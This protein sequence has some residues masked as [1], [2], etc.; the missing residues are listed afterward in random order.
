MEERAEWVPDGHFNSEMVWVMWGHWG[1][2]QMRFLKET[3]MK[4]TSF[5]R[6]T[7][8]DLTESGRIRQVLG[9]GSL[10]IFMLM[11]MVSASG[12]QAQTFTVLHDFALGTGANPTNPGIIAQGRDGSL[13]STTVGGCGGFNLDGSVFRVSPAG[14]YKMV[15]CLSTDA[16]L[17]GVY[18]GVTL[19]S[20]GN[21]YGTTYG[22]DYY[23]AVFKASAA[24]KVT[25]GKVFGA[26]PNFASPFAPPVLGLDGNWYGT[27]EEGGSNGCTYG[28]GGCGGMY[29][30]ASSFKNY[31][32]LDTLQ[33]TNGANPYSPL[34]LGSDGD[35][36]GTTYQG[37]P[38]YPSGGVIFKMTPAGVHTVL[39]NLCALHN[40]C[41]DGAN[42]L[43]GLVQ[44]AD[45]EFYG[46]ASSGG[47][48][49]YAGASA[50]GLIFKVSSTGV[51]QVLYNFCSQTSCTDGNT[52]YGG[53]VLGSD[54]NFYGTTQAGGTHNYGTIFQLTPAGNLTVLYNFDSTTGSYPE[55]T[56]VQ[57]TNGILYGDTHNGGTTNYGTFF[58]L[59]LGLPPFA[60]LVTWWGKVGGTV[61]ILGQ[62][63]KHTTSVSFNGVPA[64]TFKAIGDTYISATVPTGATSGPVT[65]V[66]ATG[67][68]TSSQSFQLQ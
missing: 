14:V 39:Y 66:T 24:G 42:P 60:K 2:F 19:G 64:T 54:G 47:T 67:T 45:G 33:Q 36:Y 41:L 1:Q 21:F 28:F 6:T 32:Q 25:F 30:I 29:K 40:N 22:G 50:G 13:Y 8:N 27:V 9:L 57:H 12:L 15:A 59:N 58:S 4:P 11:V 10:I 62:G 48:R 34:L 35:F 55:G 37:G 38:G 53:L 26:R 5:E 44:G 49:T 3:S 63:F 61:G 46:T 56:L 68:L 18:S 23:G 16:A 17:G 20:D 52:P 51:Y 7:W 31:K 65:V 43:D